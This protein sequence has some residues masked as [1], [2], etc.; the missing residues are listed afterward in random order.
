MPETEIITRRSAT[1]LKEYDGTVIT[2]GWDGNV[3]FRGITGNN[4][5]VSQGG[6]ACNCPD[7]WRLRES[8]YNLAQCKHQL[9]LALAIAHFGSI[10]GIPWNT[11]LLA[12]TIGCSIRTAEHQCEIGAV[13]ATKVH[14]V[15]VIPA[16]NAV[17]FVP[18]YQ[19]NIVYTGDYDIPESWTEQPSV[20]F[21]GNTES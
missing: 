18:V 9:M 3:M 15:W 12:S 10:G 11:T 1:A 14:Q 2:Q 16:P 5:M 21:D 13:A 19:S 7:F 4:Y 20:I 6:E 17:A 8:G